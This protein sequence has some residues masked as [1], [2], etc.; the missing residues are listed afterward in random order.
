MAEQQSQEMPGR[1]TGAIIFGATIGVALSDYAPICIILHI[2]YY[3]PAF[4]PLRYERFLLVPTFPDWKEHRQAQTF[5]LMK[6]TRISI[7]YYHPST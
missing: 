1:S 6:E 7:P 3:V 4:T 5:P 2:E